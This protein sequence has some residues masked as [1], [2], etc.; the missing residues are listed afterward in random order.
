MECLGIIFEEIRGKHES[1]NAGL[2]EFFYCEFGH[3]KG[4]FSLNTSTLVFHIKKSIAVVISIFAILSCSSMKLNDDA[5]SKAYQNYVKQN[6]LE[7][8]DS[9]VAFRLHSWRY[10]N[11][12]YIILSTSFNRPYLIKISTPCVNLKFAQAIAVNQSSSSL[13]AKFDSVSVADPLQKTLPEKCFIKSITPLSREQ[14]DEL[15]AIGREENKE[16]ILE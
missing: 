12:E 16:Q 11:S 1:F 10:L 14:A 8:T 2:A 7:R 3:Y 9:I 6:N 15:S 4:G 5:R 13:Y